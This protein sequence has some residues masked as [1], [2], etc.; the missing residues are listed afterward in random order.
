[1]DSKQQVVDT[2]QWAVDSKQW[3]GGSKQW[4]VGSKQWVVDSKQ[5]AVGRKQKH[6]AV[7]SRQ[8]TVGSGQKTVCNRQCFKF[9]KIIFYSLKFGEILIS[10]ILRKFREFREIRGSKF[11]KKFAKFGLRFRSNF[12]FR[13]NR[14]SKFRGLPS[15]QINQEFS[16]NISGPKSRFN[17]ILCKGP[18]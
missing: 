10:E 2:G 18:T 6:R 4:S 12:V 9:L 13:R 15:K 14:I 5:W 8:Q 1:M 16:N 17:L 7:C 11:V 3:A